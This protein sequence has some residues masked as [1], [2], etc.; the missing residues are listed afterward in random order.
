[1]RCGAP[2]SSTDAADADRQTSRAALSTPIQLEVR[3]YD[4]YDVQ[5][6]VQALFAEQLGMYGFADSPD[7]QVVN[8]YV[9]PQGL[10]LVA[11]APNGQPVGC[12]GCRTYDRDKLLAEVRKMFISPHTVAKVSGG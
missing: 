11:Y 8:D 1:M 6:L 3:S 7:S 4:H 12:G 10:L 5:F 9:E 2:A